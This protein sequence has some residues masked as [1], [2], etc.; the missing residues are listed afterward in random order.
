MNKLYTNFIVTVDERNHEGG[1]KCLSSTSEWEITKARDALA[2]E[3][4][5]K[6][7]DAMLLLMDIT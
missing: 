1:M 7:K 3:G 6:Q 4:S 2:V 5:Q